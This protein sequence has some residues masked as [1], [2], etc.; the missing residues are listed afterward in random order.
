VL[1]VTNDRDAT[2]PS[3]ESVSEPSC[4]LGVRGR[5]AADRCR[6][7]QLYRFCHRSAQAPVLPGTRRCKRVIYPPGSHKAGTGGCRCRQRLTAKWRPPA[8]RPD[9]PAAPTTSGSG[10]PPVR[11][12]ST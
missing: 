8:S 12:R 10:W 5:W 3:L 4:R 2:L 6:A 11:L 9:S 7:V 1:A